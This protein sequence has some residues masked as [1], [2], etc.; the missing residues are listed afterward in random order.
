MPQVSDGLEVENQDAL[1]DYH[2]CRVDGFE[3]ILFSAKHKK[4]F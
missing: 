1:E 3:L 4:K 2:V